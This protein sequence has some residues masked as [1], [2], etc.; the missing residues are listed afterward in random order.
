MANI[1]DYLLHLPAWIL[2]LIFLA[3]NVMITML[4]LLFGKTYRYTT[5]EWLI[6]GTTN[7]LNTV[8]TFA[9]CWMWAKGIISISTNIS[10][11]I[12]TDFL[13][14]FF[15]MDL[16]MYLFH[17][18]IHKT[19]LYNVIHQLHHQSVDPTPMDLFIL[20]PAEAIGFGALWLI[21][22][23]TATFNIYAIIIYLIVNVIF[24][25][26]GHLGMEPLPDKVRNSPLI[27]YLGTSTFHHDHHQ[28]IR[29]NYGFYTSIWDRIADTYKNT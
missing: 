24:G 20:H 3:E 1:L 25:L 8:V 14:L 23:T 16:L 17:Y 15:A 10:F 22:L 12:L 6:C 19:F 9:G 26:T 13:I 21:L 11:T 2:W 27:R 28:D 18:V 4:V 5:R 7:V 29:Y